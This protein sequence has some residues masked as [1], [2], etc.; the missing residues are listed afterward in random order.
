MRYDGMVNQANALVGKG[1]WLYRVVRLAMTGMPEKA[2]GL[3]PEVTCW[4]LMECETV[5]IV[6]LPVPLEHQNW[7]TKYGPYAAFK[8]VGAIACRYQYD[9]S[10]DR[11]SSGRWRPCPHS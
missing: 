2:L 10:P 8:L 7:R 1:H 6:P 9:C 5:V 11:N 4:N 3:V